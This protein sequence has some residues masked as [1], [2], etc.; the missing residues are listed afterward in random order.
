MSGALRGARVLTWPGWPLPAPAGRPSPEWRHPSCL[1][2]AQVKLGDFGIARQMD[3]TTD[4]AQTCVGTPYY[5]SPELIEGRPYN[6]LSDVWALGVVLFQMIS[7][8]YPCMP[9]HRARTP[10]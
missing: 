6:H 8:R 9:P 3:D 2:T 5:L 1:P 10:G 4:F 7:F